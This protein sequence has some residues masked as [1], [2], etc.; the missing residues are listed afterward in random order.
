LPSGAAAF[1]EEP[2]YFVGRLHRSFAKLRMT[3]N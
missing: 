1:R 3:V 2:M